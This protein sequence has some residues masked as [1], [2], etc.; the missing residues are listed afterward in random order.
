MSTSVWRCMQSWRSF[1]CVLLLRYILTISAV[2]MCLAAVVLYGIDF[3][4]NGKKKKFSFWFSSGAFVLLTFP[5]SVRLIINHL[6]H[7]HR[8][9][10]Q[11]YVVRIIWM[12]PL[13]SVERFVLLFK[14]SIYNYPRNLSH[15]HAFIH[16][17]PLYN[18]YIYITYTKSSLST[19]G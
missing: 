6:T 1:S 16:N 18:I 15:F 11:K 10:I 14:I 9:S 3:T 12:I 19:V 7:W 2:L 5:I 17:C 8:P 13:Y 4:Q